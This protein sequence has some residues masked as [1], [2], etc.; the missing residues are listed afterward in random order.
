MT[1]SSLVIVTDRGSLKAYK[2]NE[3]PTRGPSLQL[4][5]AFNI[6]D[7]HGKLIDKVTDLA[8][9]FPVSD[10]AGVHHGASISE[11]KLET[12]TDRRIYKQLAD[13]IVKI[14]KSD[15]VEG[16][17][18]AAPASMHAAIVDLLPADARDRIVEHVKSDLVKI[19]PAKLPTHFRSLQQI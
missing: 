17:S 18:F 12:E 19:E 14:V 10:G 6:T 9:R 2:V 4:V 1:P 13:Q 7:A 5:Q 16:W 3:T 11:S 8:G 15:G